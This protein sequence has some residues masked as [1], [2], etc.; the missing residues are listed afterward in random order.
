M[1]FIY[2]FMI[3]KYRQCTRLRGGGWRNRTGGVFGNGIWGLDISGDG[4]TVLY[5]IF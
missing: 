4:G 3:S 2:I 5:E 1:G